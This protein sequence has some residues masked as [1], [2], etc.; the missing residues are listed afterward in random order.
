MSVTKKMFLLS[1]LSLLLPS[2]LIDQSWGALRVGSLV[3]QRQL[4]LRRR[5]VGHY[6]KAMASLAWGCC[7]LAS[8][9][10]W[11][12]F[13]PGVGHGGVLWGSGAE[14]GGVLW[15]QWRR[16]GTPRGQWDRKRKWGGRSV[17]SS[18]F[19]EGLRG[20]FE[21]RSVHPGLVCAITIRPRTKLNTGVV[22]RKHMTWANVAHFHPSNHI[23]DNAQDDWGLEE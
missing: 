11:R 8:M 2:S 12:P 21:G 15:R 16:C 7:D 3:G 6:R 10:A 20:G 4:L 1:F 13:L 14:H 18:P 19:L 22:L 17:L 5:V 9:G 23:K